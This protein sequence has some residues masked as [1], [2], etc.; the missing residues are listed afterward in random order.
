MS[1]RHYSSLST[2]LRALALVEEG[3][4]SLR[5]ISAQLRIPKSTLHDNLPIYRSDL[6]RFMDSQQKYDYHLV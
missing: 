6:S 1:V 3:Q 2:K 5:E 4:H